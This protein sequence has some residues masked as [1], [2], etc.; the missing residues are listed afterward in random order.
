[1]ALTEPVPDLC[2]VN[3]PEVNADG[4][5]GTFTYV[6]GWGTNTATG[7]NEALMW[8]IPAPSTVVLLGAAMVLMPRRR[9]VK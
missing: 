1:M 4:G 5:N 9:R 6:V 2:S 8:V 3:G 7:R